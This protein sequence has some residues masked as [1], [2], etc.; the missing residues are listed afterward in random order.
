MLLKRILEHLRGYYREFVEAL[1][2]YE[3]G[4]ERVYAVERLAQLVA[5]SI[6]DFSAVLASR[7]RGVKPGSYKELAEWL[8]KRL[9]LDK[10]LESFLVG[11]AGFRNILVHM[12]ASIDQELEVRAFREIKDKMPA[13]MRRLEEAA[14][15]DPCI[16]DVK[17]AL[18]GVAGKLA[19]RVAIVFGSTARRGCGADLDI[20]VKLESRPSSMI[21]VGRI[22]VELE[23]AIGASVDLVILNM[24]VDPILAKTIVDEAVIVYGSE[25]EAL[26]TLLGLYKSYLEYI[27]IKRALEALEETTR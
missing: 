1:Q 4:L 20:A 13:I 18:A 9:G 21:E 11:L 27:E 10:D 14:G 23:H 24:P 26:E 2:D 25:E 6:L 8:S 3:A 22:Q 15:S 17:R 19:I 7:E 5:Q 16:D 12:Y